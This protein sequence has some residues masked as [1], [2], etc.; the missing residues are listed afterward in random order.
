MSRWGT[1]P[2]LVRT[3]TKVG[4]VRVKARLL[5]P[6]IQ[7]HPQAVIEFATL[8]AERAAVYKELPKPKREY[9]GSSEVEEV[10]LDEVAR[11]AREEQERINEMKRVEQQQRHFESTEKK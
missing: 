1:A 5:H 3:T 2:A 7:L 10:D 4:V 9:F 6:G 11:L 8:P